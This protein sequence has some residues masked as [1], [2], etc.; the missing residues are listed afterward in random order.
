M[1][2]KNHSICQPSWTTTSTITSLRDHNTHQ[3][4]EQS[5]RDRINHRISRA[6]VEHI[7]ILTPAQP[8]ACASPIPTMAPN[9]SPK[10]TMVSKR[11]FNKWDKTKNISY[12]AM[13][14]CPRLFKSAKYSKITVYLGESK[15]PSLAHRLVLGIRTAYFNN[16]LQSKF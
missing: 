3:R 9:S 11:A 16:A 8:L 7:N 6:L 2:E 5:I 12:N 4:R 14:T 15:I 13:I 10:A 1:N